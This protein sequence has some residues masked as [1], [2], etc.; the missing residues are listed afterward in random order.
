M[1]YITFLYV[2]QKFDLVELE[3]C[4]NAYLNTVSITEIHKIII[5]LHYETFTI[6]T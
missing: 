2:H 4:Y 6:L 1:K 5:L 3:I